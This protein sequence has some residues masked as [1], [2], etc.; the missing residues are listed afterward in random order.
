MRRAGLLAQLAAASLAIRM[1]PGREPP[2]AAGGGWRLCARP[3]EAASAASIPKILHQTYKTEDLPWYFKYWRQTW[4]DSTPDWEHHLWTDADNRNLVAE[5]YPWFLATYDAYV[6]P[7]QRVDAAR[8]FMMH[9]FG[10]VYADLDVEALR[11]PSALLRGGGRDLALFYDYD[12]QNHGVTNSLMA[13]VPGH[14]FWISLAKRMMR[15]QHT[16][17]YVFNMSCTVKLLYMTGPVAITDEMKDHMVQSPE[18]KVGVYPRR[19]WAPFQHNIK[20]NPCEAHDCKS[21]YPDAFLVTHWTGVWWKSGELKED[22]CT[23][24]PDPRVNML[25]EAEPDRCE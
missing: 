19:Y 11:E 24:D 22:N 4:L 2:P 3:A 9:R 17:K 20:D 21:L 12:A 25:R 8:V 6:W 14:P 23:S 5:H 10:G 7:I 18:A 1:P 15:R 13:S 16:V